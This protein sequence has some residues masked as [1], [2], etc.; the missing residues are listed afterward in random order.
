VGGHFLTS[1]ISVLEQKSGPQ[2]IFGL[3]N[4]RRHAC[5][6]DLVRGVGGAREASCQLSVLA[7]HTME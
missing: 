3:D 4:M 7:A 5:I 2:F 6:I 1:P